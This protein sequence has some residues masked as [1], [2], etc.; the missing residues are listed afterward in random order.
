MWV[1]KNDMKGRMNEEF[2]VVK[3]E[4]ISTTSATGSS[5]F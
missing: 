3:I 2:K 5:I 1:E 4:R